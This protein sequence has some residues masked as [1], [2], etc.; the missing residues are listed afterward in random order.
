MDPVIL[1]ADD[2]VMITKGLRKSIELEFGY[3]DIK[4][5]TSCSGILKEL[6]KKNY[7]HS[8]LDIGLVD[9][10]ALEILP[11]IQGLFPELRILIFSARPAA[12]YRK[13]LNLLG[14]HGYLSKD[15]G[16]DETISTLRKFFHNEAVSRKN[17]GLNNNPFSILST[18]EMEILLYIIKGLGTNEIAAILNMAASTISTFKSR[19]LEKTGCKNAIELKELA[20]AC[21]VD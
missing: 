13:A 8:I 14:I 10:S 17:R 5:V 9:G 1:L 6:K 4:S 7:T 19:I 15:Q 16:E 12:A 20:Q 3:N 21:S 11:V 18:R 2:H